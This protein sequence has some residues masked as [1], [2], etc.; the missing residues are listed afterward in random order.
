[1]TKP[2]IPENKT[3][4]IAES[5]NQGGIR[6][7]PSEDWASRLYDL[8]NWGLIVGLIIGVISTVV[9]VWMGNVKESYLKK[10]LAATNERAAHA[11]ERAAS[12]EAGNIQL[13][14]DLSK[15]QERTAKAEKDLLEVQERLKPRHQPNKKN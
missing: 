13:R 7:W 2:N 15:Q 10:G 11:E 12:V 4:P 6:M 1:M 9:L 8:A 3:I 14:T 5:G